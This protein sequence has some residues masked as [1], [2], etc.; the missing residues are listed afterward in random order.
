MGITLANRLKQKEQ[1]LRLGFKGPG[2]PSSSPASEAEGERRSDLSFPG[3]GG[4][5]T[6]SRNKLLVDP[7]RQ[8]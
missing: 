1:C 7:S 6:S 5:L 4:W 2:D 8:E 3:Y